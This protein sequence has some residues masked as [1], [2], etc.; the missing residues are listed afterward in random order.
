MVEAWPMSCRSSV[1]VQHFQYDKRDDNKRVPVLR[2]ST[3]ERRLNGLD[4]SLAL[5]DNGSDGR[6]CSSF[7]L[8]GYRGDLLE[9]SESPI[10]ARMRRVVG[11]NRLVTLCWFHAK[12]H[13]SLR[14]RV[15]D[16]DSKELGNCIT[17][18][19][20]GIKTLVG[21]HAAAIDAR[22]KVMG[23]PK[24]VHVGSVGYGCGKIVAKVDLRGTRGR[25]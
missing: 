21:A 14:R 17:K 6:A 8:I 18:G 7:L 11:T 10:Q 25:R 19:W 16:G 1:Q 9:G 23:F 5:S 15:R 12:L 4:G 13:R 20:E 22:G 3:C 24:H 2:A